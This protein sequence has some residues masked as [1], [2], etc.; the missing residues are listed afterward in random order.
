MISSGADRQRGLSGEV[1]IPVGEGEEFSGIMFPKGPVKN[2]LIPARG[3][4]YD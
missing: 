4:S 2:G 1:V 3:E